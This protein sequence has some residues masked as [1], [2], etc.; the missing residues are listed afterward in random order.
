MFQNEMLYSTDAPELAVLGPPSTLAQWRC[1]G[2]G[3]RFVKLSRR[4]LYRG[5][6]L[7]AFLE[8]RTVET[9]RTAI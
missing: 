1:K 7:N 8:E 3:P 9:E 4:V 6:D 2:V 5:S